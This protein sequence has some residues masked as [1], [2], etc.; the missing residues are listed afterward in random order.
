M[1][2]INAGATKRLLEEL[3]RSHP[4]TDEEIDAILANAPQAD[5]SESFRERALK[6]MAEA[7]R[8]RELKNNLITRHG[9]KYR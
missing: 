6:R 7:Q 5:V 3:E 2:K 8:V 1:I 4:M 9:G